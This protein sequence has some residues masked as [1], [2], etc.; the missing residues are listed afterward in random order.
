MK[1]H[2]SVFAIVTILPAVWTLPTNLARE[3]ALPTCGAVCFLG[4]ISGAV[5][6]KLDRVNVLPLPTAPLTAALQA[7]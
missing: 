3:F 7:T 5:L 1:F 4:D 6:T 2:S